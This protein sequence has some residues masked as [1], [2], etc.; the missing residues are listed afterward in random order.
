MKHLN[1]ILGI[2][3]LST[4]VGFM[5]YKVILARDTMSDSA[6]NGL[7]FLVV[8]FLIVAL[9]GIRKII[10]DHGG[11]LLGPTWDANLTTINRTTKV[12]MTLGRFSIHFGWTCER[13]ADFNIY[14]LLF[15]CVGLPWLARC[16]IV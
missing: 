5:L 15:P 9:F 1:Q 16:F 11:N 14:C 13:G 10:Q 2:I 3:F 6:H 4:F 8:L 7:M 12:L